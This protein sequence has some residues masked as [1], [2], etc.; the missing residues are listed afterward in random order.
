MKICSKCKKEKDESEFYKSKQT[1]DGLR[2]QCIIC[3]KKDRD[4]YFK[5]NKEK[6]HATCGKYRKNNKEKEKQRHKNYEEKN[7]DKIKIKKKERY[8]KNKEKVSAQGKEYYRK[9]KE[10]VINRTS[11][12]IK[13]RYQKDEKFRVITLLRRRFAESFDRYSLTGKVKSSRKYGINYEAIF[14][15]LGPCPGPREEYHIDHIFP[16]SAFDF[17]NGE[18][19]KLAFAPENHQWLKRE[20]NLSKGGRYN[21][22]EFEE[23][24]KNPNIIRLPKAQPKG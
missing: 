24:L 18:H 1:K 16:L 23:Y 21:K 9:N 17:D 3:M 15:Y 5:N 12:N 19:I 4:N 11:E 7:K 8:N 14:E 20:D 10:K 6:V 13:K 22:E 2:Y